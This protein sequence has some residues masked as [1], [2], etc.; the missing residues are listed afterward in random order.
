MIGE[1]ISKPLFCFLS[2]S[3][4]GVFSNFGVSIAKT[5]GR[6]GR[7]EREREGELR[8]EGEKATEEG[9]VEEKDASDGR[10]ERGGGEELP[11]GSIAEEK[12]KKN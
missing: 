9:G 12:K 5:L 11:E 4:S 3:V 6:G 7:G 1:E 8:V 10:E 2:P